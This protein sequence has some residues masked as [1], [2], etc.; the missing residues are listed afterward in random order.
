MAEANTK[1]AEERRRREITSL[2]RTRVTELEHGGLYPPRVTI[3]ARKKGWVVAE[4]QAWAAAR[5]A[6][7]TDD[8]L[9]A[10]VARMVAARPSVAGLL[11]AGEGT[12]E[13]TAPAP[14]AGPTVDEIADAV[15]AKLIAG[16]LARQLAAQIVSAAQVT[17]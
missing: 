15:A 2:G 1:L 14:V 9:R 7:A 4:L 11:A 10:L 13:I 17:R 6:G 5:A 16:G 3:G 8:E 12:T